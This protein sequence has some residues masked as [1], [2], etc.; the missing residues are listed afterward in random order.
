MYSVI[1]QGMNGTKISLS[2]RGLLFFAD[3]SCTGVTHTKPSLDTHERNGRWDIGIHG[4]QNRFI[5]R[6]SRFRF[7]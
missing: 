3:V 7:S 2:I 4:P 1:E 5:R 6:A